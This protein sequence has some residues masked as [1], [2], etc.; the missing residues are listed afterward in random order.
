MAQLRATARAVREAI[1]DGGITEVH[2]VQVKCPLITSAKVADAAA[3]GQSVA[4]HETYP[5]MGLSRGA[6][7]LGV[8][9]ALGE[10]PEAALSDAVIGADWS[11]HSGRASCSAGVE[12][13]R[14]EV[15]VLG[16]SPEWAGDL[17]IGHDV[18]ADAV[19]FPAVQRALASVGLAAPGQ[20]DAAA[21]ERLVAVLAKAEPATT[22]SI[23]GLR[24][25][26]NDDSDINATRHARAVVGGVIAAAVGRTDLFV[27]GGAEHQ[28]PDGGG[29]VAVIAQR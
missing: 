24:H 3:R 15:I 5:S 11:L 26:M 29:P 23:R 4:T 7:A 16:N 17:I 21:R 8:A 20:L 25:I 6:A 28:G 12:L 9:L 18:M 27:S 14:C 19:D 13:E 10:I 1:A 2:Y 22:G